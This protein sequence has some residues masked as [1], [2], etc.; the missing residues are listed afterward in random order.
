M[1]VFVR[2]LGAI[3]RFY[4]IEFGDVSTFDEWNDRY[5]SMCEFHHVARGVEAAVLAK[6]GVKRYDPAAPVDLEEAKENT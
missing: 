1:I 5:G 2:K 6:E 4:P 3:G